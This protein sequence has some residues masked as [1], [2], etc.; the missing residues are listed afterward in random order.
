MDT[1]GWIMKAV[2]S[3][4]RGTTR[5]MT[6]LWKSLTLRLLRS[7]TPTESA[8]VKSGIKFTMPF[9][10]ALATSSWQQRP[11]PLELVQD[12]RKT[13]TTQRHRQ[14]R[15][16]E[17]GAARETQK[18]QPVGSAEESSSVRQTSRRLKLSG[19]STTKKL[20]MQKASAQI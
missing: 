9:L 18:A 8:K 16:R 5:H 12:S 19:T 13:T 7:M 10:S 20:E 17:E 11:R 3:L 2:L 4:C 6:A 1:I 14:S 15:A